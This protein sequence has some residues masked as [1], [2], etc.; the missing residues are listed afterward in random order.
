MNTAHSIPTPPRID[1][2]NFMIPFTEE[3]LTKARQNNDDYL[4]SF[5]TARLRELKAEQRNFLTNKKYNH[6]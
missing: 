2:V 4:I 1:V 3:K 5:H 6:N